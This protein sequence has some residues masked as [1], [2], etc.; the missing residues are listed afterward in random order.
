MTIK[1]P[2]TMPPAANSFLSVLASQE[3]WLESR[4]W[5][6]IGRNP[7]GVAIWK[8][9]DSGRVKEEL[10][11]GPVLMDKDKHEFRIQQLMVPSCDY[12]MGT[13]QAVFVQRSRDADA[14][15]Q[16]QAKAE[17]ALAG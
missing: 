13:E 17:P 4:G 11:P 3:E 16:N 14:A 2:A 5:N 9:P 6:R 10:K 15:K 7:M 8:D 12:P 1:P